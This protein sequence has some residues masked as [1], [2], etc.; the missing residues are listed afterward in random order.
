MYILTVIAFMWKLG[1][2]RKKL[3]AK[4]KKIKEIESRVEELEKHV[5]TPE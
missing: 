5:K 1:D 3:L 4:D 2:S